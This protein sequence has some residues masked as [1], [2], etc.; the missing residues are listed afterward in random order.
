MRL[1]LGSGGFA[2]IAIGWTPFF[3]WRE[4]PANGNHP[5]I[6]DDAI[7]GESAR[8]SHVRRM[9][10]RC[11]DQIIAEKLDRRRGRRRAQWPAA[12][13]ATM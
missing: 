13:E 4:G 12:C 5:A 11:S 1:H 6:L 8:K 2:A 9:R 3:R 10:R 7:V